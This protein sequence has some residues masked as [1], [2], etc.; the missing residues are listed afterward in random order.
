MIGK[1]FINQVGYSQRINIK[2]LW[3]FEKMLKVKI[4]NR[5]LLNYYFYINLDMNVGIRV[6]N[7]IREKNH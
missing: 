5:N 6:R 4:C 7:S 2:N 3:G 1:I